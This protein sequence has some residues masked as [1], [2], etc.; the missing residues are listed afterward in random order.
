M[1]LVLSE[2]CRNVEN[3]I[4][5]DVTKFSSRVHVQPLCTEN[6]KPRTVKFLIEAQS[7]AVTPTARKKTAFDARTPEWAISTSK[8]S[9]PKVS[10]V[11]LPYQPATDRRRSRKSL[12]FG[13]KMSN[14]L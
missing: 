1:G 4:E 5:R 7:R 8:S 9:A 12:T 10:I 6:E 11:N 14:L 2:V 3:I 13:E